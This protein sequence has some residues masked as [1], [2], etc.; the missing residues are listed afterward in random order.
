MK[1]EKIKLLLILL[2]SLITSTGHPA[3]PRYWRLPDRNLANQYASENS[4]WHSLC[5]PSLNP[6]FVSDVKLLHQ[7][8]TSLKM[9]S[10]NSLRELFLKYSYPDYH[11]SPHIKQQLHELGFL[12]F[13]GNIRHSWHILIMLVLVPLYHIPGEFESLQEKVIIEDIAR[14]YPRLPAFLHPIPTTLPEEFLSKLVEDYGVFPNRESVTAEIVARLTNAAQSLSPLPDFG[15]MLSI[16]S[17]KELFI[18]LGII[19]DYGFLSF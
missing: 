9:T 10:P 7:L 12:K 11:L 19:V 17:L 2:F 15:T 8:L 5:S 13:D 18:T 6:Q 1:C 16:K 3:G 14:K 4:C